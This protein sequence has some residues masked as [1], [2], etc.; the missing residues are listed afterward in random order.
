MSGWLHYEAHG[1]PD[2]AVLVCRSFTVAITQVASSAERES[3]LA[4]VI[5]FTESHCYMDG[6]KT[7][8]QYFAEAYCIPH[9]PPQLF[10]FKNATN[11]ST[12]ASSY[13]T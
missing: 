6:I 8:K 4:I 11:L 2:Q 5:I 7:F 3:R 1:L 9:G 12:S 13:C 10:V